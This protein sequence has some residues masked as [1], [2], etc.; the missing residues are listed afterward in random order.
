MLSN[1]PCTPFLDDSDEPYF[2]GQESWE[3]FVKTETEN[4]CSQAA[5]APGVSPMVFENPTEYPERMIVEQENDCDAYNQQRYFRNSVDDCK[6]KRSGSYRLQIAYNNL[7]ETTQGSECQWQRSEQEEEAG[8]VSTRD[9]RFGEFNTFD[10]DGLSSAT[11]GDVFEEGVYDIE[12]ELTKMIIKMFQERPDEEKAYIE[13]IFPMLLDSVKEAFIQSQLPMTEQIVA[14]I[15]KQLLQS[16]LA[17]MAEERDVLD[18]LTQDEMEETM[19][20]RPDEM[21]TEEELATSNRKEKRAVKGNRNGSSMNHLNENYIS[22]V[23]QFAKR[24]YPEDKE[25]QRIG[26]VRNVSASN[27]R[28]IVGTKMTDG[29]LARRAKARI[30]ESG[31][32]LIGNVEYWMRD[33]YF[34]QCADREKYICHKKKALRDLA[35]AGNY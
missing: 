10:N 30:A 16:K 2:V 31:R 28:K 27:F 18:C 7:S 14:A 9:S 5:P 33:G 22:N 35:L 3:A 12:T 4:L 21:I 32:E 6:L 15:V 13:Q 24:S 1:T 8:S 20:A 19:Y 17:L 26:S 25:L 29:I 34:E 23:F 11:D